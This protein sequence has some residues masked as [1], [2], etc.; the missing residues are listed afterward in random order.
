MNSS[1]NSPAAQNAGRKPRIDGVRTREAVL[2][3]AARAASLHGFEGI[4]FGAL[5]KELGLSKSSLFAH[6]G[7]KEE[8]EIATIAEAER[9]FGETVVARV[10]S[11][12]PGIARLRTVRDAFFDHVRSGVFPGGCFFAAVAA[13]IVARPGRVRDRLLGCISDWKSLLGAC[14]DE[15]R[16]LGEIDSRS[17]LSQM[18]FELQA[19]LQAGNQ[20]FALTRDPAAFERA[21]A[22]VEEII[23]RASPRSTPST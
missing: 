17:D 7:S 11:A 16:N 15:A 13:G 4:S 22:G 6:F 20:T 23:R 5:A 10:R 14:L 2:L 12:P 18:A 8:M 19:M 3:A 21:D 1:E 9:I